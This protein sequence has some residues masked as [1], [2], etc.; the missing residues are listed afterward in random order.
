MCCWRSR[1]AVGQRTSC[2][3]PGR[4][5]GAGVAVVALTGAVSGPLGQESDV[6]MAVPDDNTARVQEVH[7]SVLHLL[8]EEV[9]RALT[10]EVR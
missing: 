9:E 6:V 2:W 7:L 8:C 5:A 10:D 4:R 3:L 1:R